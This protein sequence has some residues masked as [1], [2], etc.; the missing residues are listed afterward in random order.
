M[1]K[2]K[3]IRDN[4][5]LI[6]MAIITIAFLVYLFSPFQGEEKEPPIKDNISTQQTGQPSQNSPRI[7][8]VPREDNNPDQFSLF[9]KELERE[10]VDIYLTILSSPTPFETYSPE[11]LKSILENHQ[12]Q[13][14]SKY[15]KFSFIDL[16][17]IVNFDLPPEFNGETRFNI[18]LAL[19]LIKIKEELIIPHFKE[20]TQAE[21]ESRI[22]LTTYSLLDNQ[23]EK[24]YHVIPFLFYFKLLLDRI[25]LFPTHDITVYFHEKA[26][27]VIDLTY[28]KHLNKIKELLSFSTEGNRFKIYWKEADGIGPD[29]TKAFSNINLTTFHFLKQCYLVF[30][31]G[32]NPG[33][34][35][36][37]DD[38]C[39]ADSGDIELVEL[40]IQKEDPGRALKISRIYYNP[41]N[42]QFVVVLN[43]SKSIE[44]NIFIN[45]LWVKKLREFQ[46]NYRVIDF[47]DSSKQDESFRNILKNF[48][49]YLKKNWAD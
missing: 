40:Q 28:N 47:S 21:F 32:D 34:N 22:P 44:D 35:Q 5:L 6:S 20:F 15:I 19:F 16:G 43:E 23:L 48:G 17:Q 1:L 11:K 13:L 2:N 42:S 12:G 37:I 39:S 38:L 29:D 26:N 8:E 49:N 31:D 24:D 33:N 41:L 4:V 27:A 36:W 30:P 46:K 9:S 7:I 45:R 10:L 18:Y 14:F 25:D 3:E